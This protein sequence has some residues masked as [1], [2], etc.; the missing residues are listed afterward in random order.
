MPDIW[1]I[2]LAYG[3]GTGIGW[4]FALNQ[5]IES[6]Y[7]IFMDALIKDGYIK[8]KGSGEELEI[9]KYWED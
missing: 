6:S 7:E 2:L 1:W 8:T 5:R 4:W 3:A 9:L